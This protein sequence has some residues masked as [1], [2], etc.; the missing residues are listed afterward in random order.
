MSIL[1]KCVFNNWNDCIYCKIFFLQ[2][3]THILVHVECPAKHDNAQPTKCREI[4][5]KVK[6]ILLKYPI[7]EIRMEGLNTHPNTQFV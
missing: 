5:Y 7:H 1:K 4:M 2:K 6:F 3:D